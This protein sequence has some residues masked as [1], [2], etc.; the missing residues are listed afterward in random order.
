MALTIKLCIHRRF[1]CV[2]EEGKEDAAPKTAKETVWDWD[3]LNDVKAIWLRPAAD[4]T[5]DDYTKFYKAL[6]KVR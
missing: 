1:A 4:V 5:E 3:V 6:A 2:A